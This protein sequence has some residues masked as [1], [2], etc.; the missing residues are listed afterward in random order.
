MYK[1]VQW[2]SIC[3]DNSETWE[4]WEKKKNP[5]IGNYLNESQYI[6]LMEYYVATEKHEKDFFGLIW[7]V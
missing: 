5:W 6:L 1:Y 4:P 3:T 7:K 2:N